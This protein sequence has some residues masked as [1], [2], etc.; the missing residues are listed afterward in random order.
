[1]PENDCEAAAEI[2]RTGGKYA[3]PN[4]LRPVDPRLRWCLPTGFHWKTMRL[5]MTASPRCRCSQ[6]KGPPQ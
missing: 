5:R 4:C 6:F 3:L 1:M 2:I